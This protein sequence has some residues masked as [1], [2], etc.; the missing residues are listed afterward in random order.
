M[1]FRWVNREGHPAQGTSSYTLGDPE[2]ACVQ[3]RYA[4]IGDA[5]L[6]KYGRQRRR[7]Q[8]DLRLCALVHGFANE[9][10]RQAINFIA[11][12]GDRS[13]TRKIPVESC[14]VDSVR[15]LR[16]ENRKLKTL[17]ADLTLDKH[18]LQDVLSK[19]V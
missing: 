1:F 16:E 11:R 15:R 7:C 12:Q 5:P 18:I 17:V 3:S 2:N 13:G 10:K 19:K 14:S 4:T 9:P 6:M 8:R